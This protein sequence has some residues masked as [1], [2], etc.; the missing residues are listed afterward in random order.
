MRAFMGTDKKTLVENAK[1]HMKKARRRHQEM[2]TEFT[3]LL[4]Q[5]A[6]AVILAAADLT[7]TRVEWNMESSESFKAQV[8]KTKYFLLGKKTLTDAEWK[9]IFD[10]V[11]GRL[12]VEPD[13]S[14]KP[15][16]VTLPSQLVLIWETV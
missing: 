16:D 10:S 2:L 7:L 6:P 8:E 4:V 3:D 9:D 13:L 11:I 1:L 12:K 14:W 5:E 15:F